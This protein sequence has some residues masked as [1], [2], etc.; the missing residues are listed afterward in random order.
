MRGRRSYAGV[1][2][3][4]AL[5]VVA[6]LC[7]SFWSGA[8]VGNAH[9]DTYPQHVLVLTAHPDDECMFFAPT[10][11]ALRAH[12]VQVSALCLSQGNADGLGHLRTSEL[13][14][15]YDVLGVPAKHVACIDD[16]RL[17]DGLQ[18]VWSPAAVRDVVK[19]HMAHSDVDTILTFDE[20]GVS[21]HPNHQA[22]FHGA[23]LL[24]HEL[25]TQARA[26]TLW[27]LHTYSWRIKFGGALVS[28]LQRTEPHDYLFRSSLKAY[29][30][31][32]RAMYQH[33]TQLVW[34]RYLYVLSSSYMFAN[35][36]RIVVQ[37]L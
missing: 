5:V 6:H 22:L 21:L 3:A 33:Q 12:G 20:G 10:I 28:L 18:Q 36:V 2:L 14:R 16:P 35:R 4:V 34:F 23:E 8:Y 9:L 13:V 26:V 15:S 27:T 7:Q 24:Q 32:L 31:S 11:H 25:A 37:A 29:I 1:W 30:Q 17:Q 19:A